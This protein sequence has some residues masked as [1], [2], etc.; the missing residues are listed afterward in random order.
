MTYA[1]VQEKAAEVVVVVGGE[2][3]LEDGAAEVPVWEPVVV[4]DLVLEDGTAEVLVWELVAEEGLPDAREQALRF[5]SW[6]S[7]LVFVVSKARE[8]LYFHAALLV[9]S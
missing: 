4:G 2:L 8:M 9:F 3:V 6:R 5:R 1:E 7:R